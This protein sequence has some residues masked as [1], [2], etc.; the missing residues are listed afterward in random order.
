MSLATA[1]ILSYNRHD[2]LR[3]QILYYANKPIHL[4]IADGS[5]DDWGSGE[6]GS[7]GEM[8]WEYF[9]ISGSGFLDRYRKA[10]SKV[11]TEFMFFIDDEECILPSGV[12]RATCFLEAN[13]D[14][15]CA[16][17][18]VGRASV[19][20]VGKR[21]LSKTFSVADWN[22]FSSKFDLLQDDFRLRIQSLVT[23]NRT[24]NIYY[25]VHR[26]ELVKKF[27]ETF[28]EK[29]LE[30]KYLGTPEILFCCFIVA[31]GKWQMQNYP[32]WFRYGGSVAAPSGTPK[33]IS[34][35]SA[36]EVSRELVRLVEDR[37]QTLKSLPNENDF[38]DLLVRDF[39]RVYGNQSTKTNSENIDI[40]LY[41]RLL[42]RKAIVKL[43]SFKQ[44]LKINLFEICPTMYERMFQGE[45]TRVKTYSKMFAEGNKSVEH[46]LFRFEDIW[47]RYRNGLSGSD[48]ELEL[49]KL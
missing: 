13:P 27:A 18:R 9:K 34:C 35:N 19:G 30:V 17:G 45:A 38:K 6:S 2:A 33:Y 11:E 41:P 25:Q 43:A 10:I 21:P 40:R 32:Y 39:L 48:L 23:E 26:T 44:Y 36:S 14:H 46:E 49:S 4:I 22:Y 20:G 8:T 24:A 15:S 37:F 31:H 12:E 42:L 7:I 47:D 3:R 1:V 5:D 28:D 29:I 16:G